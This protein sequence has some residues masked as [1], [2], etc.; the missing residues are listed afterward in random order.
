MYQARNYMIAQTPAEAYD[1][2]VRAK[3]NTLL[4]GCGWLKMGRKFIGTAIDISALGLDTIEQDEDSIKIGAMV[5]LRALETSEIAE[6]HFGGILRECLRSIVGVQFRGCATV[7]GS[8]FSRFGF[9]DILTALLVLDAQVELHNAG[10]I[11]LADFINMP[12]KKD[13]LLRVIIKKNGCVAGYQSLRNTR[14]DFPVLAVAV[15]KRGAGWKVSVGARP[16]A[17]RLA[18]QAQQKLGAAP[19]DAEIDEACRLAASE[20]EYGSNQRAS[21]EYRRMLAPVLVKRA[22]KEAMGRE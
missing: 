12:R 10:I 16:A 19:T 11:P 22:V 13:L 15:S 7:G 6:K 5:T 4:G 1:E 20:L 18:V 17:A 2:L 9:S 8:V 3:N 21:A 14:T